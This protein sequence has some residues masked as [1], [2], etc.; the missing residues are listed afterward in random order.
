MNDIIE[1]VQ[2]SIGTSLIG[3]TGPLYDKFVGDF[4]QFVSDTQ[5][6]SFTANINVRLRIIIYNNA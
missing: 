3:G 5:N 4:K 1:A 6:V 2:G